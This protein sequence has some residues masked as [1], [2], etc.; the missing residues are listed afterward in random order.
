MIKKCG[1]LMALLALTGCATTY[2]YDGQKY[3]SKEKFQQASDSA[4]AAKLST[5]T[6]L[7]APLTPKKLIFAIQ[8]GRAHV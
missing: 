4:L 5:I 8:I 2:T 1:V 7:S 3:D 6:P